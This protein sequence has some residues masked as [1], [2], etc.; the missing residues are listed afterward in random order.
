M[1]AG[2]V[3]YRQSKFGRKKVK[4][5]RVGSLRRRPGGYRARSFAMK[6]LRT[7][8]LL[9]IELKF[10]DCAANGTALTAPTDASGG[11]LNPSTGIIG[12]LS[13]PA[14]GDAANNRDGNKIVVKSVLLQ[15]TISV[16]AQANQTAADLSCTV[17][18]ALVMDTQANGVTLNSED[19]FTNLSAN[20]SQATNLFRNM[21]YTQRF[22]VLKLKRI[23]LRIPTLTW[24]GTNIEQTGFSTQWKLGVK[25]MMMGVTFTTGSTTADIANVTNNA[26]HLVGYCDNASLVPTVYY[27]SRVRFV[28]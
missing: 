19:V 1:E 6:N 3:R 24:D 2:L 7:G 21:S 5:R 22:K 18:L 23:S 28:G 4:K 14:L 11:E 25:K 8:G 16:A 13:A 20:A 9:G 12:C 15:G 17:F 26:L 10:V 27:N